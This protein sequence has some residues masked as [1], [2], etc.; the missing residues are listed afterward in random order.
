MD[1]RDH[2]VVG[3]PV[4]VVGEG[5]LSLVRTLVAGV[6][7]NPGVESNP[8]VGSSPGLAL[9]THPERQVVAAVLVAH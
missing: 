3:T 2:W 8:V 5:M 7:R 1:R 4:L 6:V 9:P